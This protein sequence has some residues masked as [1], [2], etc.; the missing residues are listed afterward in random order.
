MALSSRHEVRAFYDDSADGY[1]DMMDEEIKL[2]LYDVVLSGLADRI[3]SL[4]GPVLDSSCGS[5]HMLEMLQKKYTHRRQ[6]LG[7]D[8]SPKMVTIARERLGGTAS[9]SQGDMSDLAEISD[10]TCAAVISFFSLHHI[11]A[12]ELVACFTEWHRVLVLRGQLVIAT[13]EGEG[14]ID[15]GDQSGILTQRYKESELVDA[16]KAANFQIESHSVQPVEGFEMDAV[17]I[18]AAKRALDSL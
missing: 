5:G 14:T 18:I 12:S 15:Y 13:W 8:L 7:L 6:L 9:I 4:D 3:S 1:N 17:H 11:G 10:D 2:P 16:L